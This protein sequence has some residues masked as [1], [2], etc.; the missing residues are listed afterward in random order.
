MR[1]RFLPLLVL[2]A[3]TVGYAK[4]QST[5]PEV[6][7]R[8]STS[9]GSPS[10]AY[11]PSEILAK[12]RNV[13]ALVVAAN[14]ESAKLGTGFFVGGSGLLLTNFH[15]VEGTAA[16]AIRVPGRK[17]LLEATRATGYD[18]DNDLVIL[19]IDG[20][21]AQTALLADSDKVYSGQPVVEVGNPEGLEQS[22]SDGLISGIRD[23]HGRKLFQISAP[24]SEGSSGS[25]V[26]DDQ[27][28]VIGV[29]ASSLEGGQ[30]LNFAIP[31]NYA[32]PLLVSRVTF[33]L[34]S[35]PRRKATSVA[36]SASTARQ[37][38]HDPTAKDQESAV[39]AIRRIADEIRAC[40]EVTLMTQTKERHPEYIR[41]FWRAPT[42]VRYDLQ[43]SN[44]LIAP[45]VG[46]VEFSVYSGLGR[47]WKTPEQAGADDVV[48]L[49][50]TTRHRYLYRIGGGGVQLDSRT[51]Y[52]PKSQ[53]WVLEQGTPE[54]CWQRAASE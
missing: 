12:N 50:L 9:Q 51:Y 23:T 20:A 42:D 47:F 40:P 26:F 7:H 49:P 38:L 54:M 3:L 17:E 37:P 18:L 15:V 11:T 31:I 35:L 44:S 14:A 6:Q 16:V 41:S 52:D 43:S 4:A 30:N 22:V 2:T 32:K 10:R 8:N 45:Y 33:S 24:V 46:I 36:E 48:I 28:E 5:A 53:V 27:G 29:V 1:T 13:I 19:Q 34:D 25:P 39:Q 21:N